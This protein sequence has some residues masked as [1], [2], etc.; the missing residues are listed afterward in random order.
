MSKYNYKKKQSGVGKVIAFFICLVICAGIVCAAGYGSKTADGWF[1]NGNVATWFD[2]WGKGNAP[3][4][5]ANG[6]PTDGMTTATTSSQFMS[7]RST[8]MTA[9][10]SS[11]T[12]STYRLTATVEPADADYQELEWLVSFE[13]SSSAWASGKAAS[14]FVNVAPSSDTHNATVTCLGDF[15]EPVIITVKS[16]DNPEAYATCRCDYVKRVKSL[17][18][19][20]EDPTFTSA[21]G[22][23]YE[24]EPTAYTIDSEITLG[25]V[26]IGVT[27]GFET[28]M[29]EWVRNSSYDLEARELYQATVFGVSADELIVDYE[30]STLKFKGNDP[31][32][33]FA[34]H[35]DYWDEESYYQLTPEDVALNKVICKSAFKSTIQT[36]DGAHATL[37]I[38]YRITYNGE[39]YGGGKVEANVNFN[40]ETIKV[41]VSSVKLD[42]SNII[43]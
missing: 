33:L 36:Y 3:T 12:D 5:S 11:R 37:A 14:D 35:D 29:R 4:H 6:K 26:K 22:Y 31:T 15:G 21:M 10:A 19:T 28:A 41:P 25:T 42:S 13:N 39:S 38:E 32:A 7:L 18:F 9:G 2:S 27:Y 23:T 17:T 34:F 43:M 24:I 8:P 40:F 16:K 30:N 20:L 1:K